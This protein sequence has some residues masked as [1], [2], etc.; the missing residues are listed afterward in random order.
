MRVI[1][2]LGKLLADQRAA[3]AVEYALILALIFLGMVGAVSAL[4]GGTTGMWTEVERKTIAA[5]SVD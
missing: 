5:M 3:T 4:G 2:T 1:E